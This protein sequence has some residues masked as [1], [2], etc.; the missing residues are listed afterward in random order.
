MS[1]RRNLVLVGY[2]GSGKTTVGRELAGRLHTRQYDLDDLIVKRQGR[3]IPEIFA[4]EGEEGFRDIETE[5]IRDLAAQG[6][7]GLVYSAGGGAVLRKENRELLRQLGTV[8]WLMVDAQTVIERLAGS[9]GRP[10]L[11]GEDRET[12]VRAMLESR[13]EAYADAAQLRVQVDG[14]TPGQ[15]AEEILALSV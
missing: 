6:Q 15:I 4:A 5:L 1:E 2:M 7:Q 3:S 14:K 12:K 9:T 11:E 10:L 13:Q 8:I